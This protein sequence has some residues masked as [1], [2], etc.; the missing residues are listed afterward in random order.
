[1]C[2]LPYYTPL[3]YY[4]APESYVQIKLH[5]ANVYQRG[6]NA[7]KNIICDRGLDLNLELRTMDLYKNREQEEASK[8]GWEGFP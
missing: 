1:M 8:P 5:R 6:A 4:C 2:Y 7:D 3:F